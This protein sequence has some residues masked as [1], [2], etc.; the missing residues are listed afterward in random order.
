[1]ALTLITAPAIE[2]VL[3]ADA[4]VHLRIPSAVTA[5]D[6]YITAL[7]VVA[8]QWIENYTNR[9]LITQTWDWTMDSFPRF[10]VK[11]PKSP[12]QSVTNIKYYDT[13]DTE[14]T[15][16]SDYY[17]V[18]I[19]STPGRI[20]IAYGCATP[21]VSLRYMNGVV[22]R[23]IAGYGLAAANVPTNVIHAIK[24]MISHYYEYREPVLSTFRGEALSEV[25][26][27]VYSLLANERIQ[28]L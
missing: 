21:S 25:P 11:V 2:P 14:A 23:F 5:D 1:M 15:W 16:D 22:V 18:D 28:P 24:V 6:T 27:T 20:D 3:I 13:D 7:I 10:P 17:A 12:L 9:S 26:L 19:A 4:K 8:R